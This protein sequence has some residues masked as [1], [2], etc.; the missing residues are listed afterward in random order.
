MV[1][2]VARGLK[3]GRRFTIHARASVQT[4]SRTQSSGW[5]SCRRGSSPWLWSRDCRQIPFSWSVHRQCRVV[6]YTEMGLD[7]TEIQ[8]R[9]TS[10][11]IVV[12]THANIVRVLG[13]AKLAA[14]SMSCRAILS[15]WFRTRAGSTVFTHWGRCKRASGSRPRWTTQPQTR[16]LNWGRP[17]CATPTH[18]AETRSG[19][20]MSTD[21]DIWSVL[22]MCD[23]LTLAFGVELRSI[24]RH[25]TYFDHRRSDPMH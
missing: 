16:S 22:V 17:Q 15:G 1:V 23:D 3:H 13:A 7:L 12:V 9:E 14:C 2:V 8:R 6:R 21:W 18:P 5:T 24:L 20:S 25:Q 11:T 4:L 19:S 10:S